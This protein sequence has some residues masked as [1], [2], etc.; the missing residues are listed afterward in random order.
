MCSAQD[1]LMVLQLIKY[2]IILQLLETFAT[3]NIYSL[4]C[5]LPDGPNISYMHACMKWGI[6]ELV[7]WLKHV[8]WIVLEVRTT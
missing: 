6:N 2:F 5:V 8:C 3:G 4:S 1:S 7:D